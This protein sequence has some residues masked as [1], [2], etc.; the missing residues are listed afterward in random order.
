MMLY[1]SVGVV[2]SVNKKKIKT[3]YTSN[4]DTEMKGRGSHA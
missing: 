4:I 2:R 1:V 3:T